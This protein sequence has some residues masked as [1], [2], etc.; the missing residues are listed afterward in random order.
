LRFHSLVLLHGIHQQF[1]PDDRANHF[2][3]HLKHLA[4]RIGRRRSFGQCRLFG[5]F[6]N[7]FA[8]RPEFAQRLFREPVVK[9]FAVH[10]FLPFFEKS[11]RY[12]KLYRQ[13]LTGN[14]TKTER[15]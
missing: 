7:K 10:G 12:K 9:T 4:E 15:N 3:D 14:L 8:A 6:L 1:R 2:R 13:S 5:Q 11:F